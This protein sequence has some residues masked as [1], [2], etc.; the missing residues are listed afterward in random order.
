[1]LLLGHE[2]ASIRC[3]AQILPENGLALRWVE[4]GEVRTDQLLARVAVHLAEGRIDLYGD[5]GQIIDNQPVG[6]CLEDTLVPRFGFPYPGL[7]PH[8]FGVCCVLPLA[9]AYPYLCVSWCLQSV[10]FVPGGS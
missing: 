1:M 2:L 4:H 10:G 8:P 5:P 7:T 6:G 3:R 9:A